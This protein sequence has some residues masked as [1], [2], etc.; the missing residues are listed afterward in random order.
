MV[1]YIKSCIDHYDSDIQKAAEN[2]IFVVERYG[3]V[4]SKSYDEESAAIDDLIRELRSTKNSEIAI[5]DLKGRLDNLEQESAT[6]KTLMNSRDAETATK[7]TQNMRTAR[8]LV[9]K[10]FRS[11]RDFM[12][13]KFTINPYDELLE[14]YIKD[15]NAVSN[16]Y[17]KYVD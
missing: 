3:K 9:D 1:N 13:A 10:L 17:K 2:I 12:D 16:R 14:N 6:F 7:P 15:F 4:A 8:E 11:F 5:L